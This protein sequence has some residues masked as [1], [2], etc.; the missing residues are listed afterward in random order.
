MNWDA[1]GAIAELLGA[2]GVIA[3]LLY[4]GHQ[5]RLSSR[6]QR[7][8]TQHDVLAEFRTDI[9]QVLQN[10]NLREAFQKF[11]RGEDIDREHRFDLA[12]FIGNEFRTYEEL[13]LAY[14]DRNV[15]SDLWE[16]RLKNLRDFY[17]RHPLTQR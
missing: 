8:A 9:S 11:S 6:A 17:L 12:L 4:L 7:A 14:L 5:I 3:T 1:L 13:Y 10:R 16:S 2:I 15:V